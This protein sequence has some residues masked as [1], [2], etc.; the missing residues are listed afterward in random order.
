YACPSHGCIKRMFNQYAVILVNP[1]KHP[2][3]KHEL[4]QQFNNWLVSLEGQNAIANY[5][6]KGEQLFFPNARVM[7]TP[8]L[9]GYVLMSALGQ[10]RTC[11]VQK[12]MSAL[13]Q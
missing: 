11:A 5:R 12:G 6:I 10:K 1:A 9:I 13:P 3:V 2:G 8:E 4:A 7:P